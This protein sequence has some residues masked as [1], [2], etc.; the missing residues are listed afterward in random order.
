MNKTTKMNAHHGFTLV[1]LIVVIVI[2]VLLAGLIAYL[3][4]SAREQSRRVKCLSNQKAIWETAQYIGGQPCDSFHP[5]LPYGH[6]VGQSY[7]MNRPAVYRENGWL[8]D[9]TNISP[10]M[11]ICPSMANI[12]KPANSLTNITETNSC[13]VVFARRYNNDGNK[14]FICDMNG[15]NTIPSPTANGWGGNHK[16][17]GGNMVFVSGAGRWVNTS[18][19]TNPFYVNAFIVDTNAHQKILKY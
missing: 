3:M 6:F 15:F 8:N 11:F 18:E 4:N 14:I 7:P 17:K 12:V 2:I 10:N 9:S 16:G 13:Y 19:I 5:D 1:E